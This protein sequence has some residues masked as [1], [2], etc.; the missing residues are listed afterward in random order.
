MRNVASTW[1]W[2]SMSTVTVVP[3]ARAA[4]PMREMFSVAVFSPWSARPRPTA[5]GLTDTSVA[6][7]A[8]SP[9]A[10]R[11]ASRA[12]Y[13]PVTIA[14]DFHYSL[15]HW[16]EDDPLAG[17]GA[18]S[19]AGAFGFYPWIDATRA[20][21]GILARHDLTGDAG[22]KSVLCGSL[23]RKAWVSGVAQ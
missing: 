11:L 21:Y 17:D 2:S 7:P 20:F 9:A 16:V 12:L 22:N 8:V 18:F 14:G 4:A 13:S 1:L 6:A 15:G 5:V 3:A 10:S 23:I 19:S